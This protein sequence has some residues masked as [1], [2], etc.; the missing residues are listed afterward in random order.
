MEY[1]TLDKLQWQ[2]SLLWLGSCIV[3]IRGNTGWGLFQSK[4]LNQMML[5]LTIFGENLTPKIPKFWQR[6]VWFFIY[7]RMDNSEFHEMFTGVSFTFQFVGAFPTMS[8]RHFGMKALQL[9]TVLNSWTL[10]LTVKIKKRNPLSWF[11]LQ[12]T[13][14]TSEFEGEPQDEH[15][16]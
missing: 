1:E 2:M 4:I 16:I 12:H 13:H 11:G 7:T 14:F 10:H 3:G 8:T 9:R 6:W 15:V 5:T